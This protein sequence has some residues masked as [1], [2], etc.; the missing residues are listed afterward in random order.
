MVKVI[1]LILLSVAASGCQAKKAEKAEVA[2]EQQQ[3]RTF[4]LP[5]LPA[6]LQEPAER[7]DYL[8]LHYWDHFDFKDTAYVHLP[9]VTE[10]A[11]ADYLSVL[12]HTR[13]ETA[14]RAIREMLGKSADEPRMF[15]YFTDLYDRYLYDANSPMRNEELY[16]PVLETIIASPLVDE[17]HKVRPKYRLELAMKNRVG[18]QAADFTYTLANGQKRRM[19]AIQS[20]YLILYFNNPDCNACVEIANAL[21]NSLLVKGMIA[22]KKL[23]VLAIYPDAD[24]D[25]WKDHLSDFP[26]TWING[27]DAE[28]V[29]EDDEIYDLKAI[30]MIYLL[31]K[32]KNVLLKD[33]DTNRLFSY[34]SENTGGK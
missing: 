11:F 17:D 14:D 26:E 29:I 16:I 10:Q 13:P 25:I 21:A 31:D 12:E 7:A 3:Q 32:N 24:L 22:E 18:Q 19:H 20:D 8:A 1:L 33:V 34:L 27:Y 5:D 4:K 30:P 28:R 6:V 2:V 15:S 23:Q 9:E